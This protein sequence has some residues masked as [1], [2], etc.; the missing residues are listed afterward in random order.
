LYRKTAEA[1]GNINGLFF[2]PA[3]G[4]DMLFRNA[5]VFPNFT[6]IY[7]IRFTPKVDF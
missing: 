3:D 6:A 5:G 2:D 4:D 1:E 7:A